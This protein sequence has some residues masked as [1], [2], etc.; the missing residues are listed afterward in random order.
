MAT[1]NCKTDRKS[2][3]SDRGKPDTQKIR[4]TTPSRCPIK[5]ALRP[6]GQQMNTPKML[7]SPRRFYEDL[8]AN[9]LIRRTTINPQME[10]LKAYAFLLDLTAVAKWPLCMKSKQWK[11]TETL[12]HQLSPA[13]NL[14]LSFN[15]TQ[16]WCTS[17]LVIT[18]YIN[19]PTNTNFAHLCTQLPKLYPTVLES[20]SGHHYRFYP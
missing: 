17:H 15:P 20:D 10:N 3:C 18:V 7:P 14:R 5:K 13:T 9:F 2:K 6:T 1:A 16:L 11:T 8:H 4:K 12:Q 19:P